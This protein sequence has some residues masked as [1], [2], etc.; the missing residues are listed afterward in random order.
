MDRKNEQLI[1]ITYRV[2]SSAALSCRVRGDAPYSP[3]KAKL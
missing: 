3:G 2:G 1:S